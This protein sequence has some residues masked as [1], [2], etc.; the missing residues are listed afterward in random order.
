MQS[1]DIGRPSVPS[2]FFSTRNVSL[3]FGGFA[4][5]V[6]AFALWSRIPNQRD[7]MPHGYCYL[8][9]APLI[10]LHVASDAL[11]FLSY[12]SI[13][14]T[15]LYFIRRRRDV[16]FNWMFLCFGTFI[17]AC[18]FTHAMEVWTLWH[19]SYW[20]SGAVKA[21]TAFASVPTAVLLVRLVPQALAL[22]SPDALRAES[23]NRKR[24]ETKFRGLMESAPDAIV[25]VNGDGIITL[26]NAQTEKVFGYPREELLGQTVDLLVPERFRHRHTGHRTSFF[27]EPKV[28]PM[29]AS[30][31]LYGLRKDGNEFPVEI[32]LSPLETEE[33]ILVSAAIRDITERKIAETAL[34][35]SEER[36]SSAF[37]NAPI[38]MAL[39]ALDG[40]WLKVNRALCNLVGYS[41]EELLAG[42]FQDITHPD[43]LEADLEHV[44]R[45]V[46][47]EIPS[48]QMEKRYFHKSGQTIWIL[49][50]V[51]LVRDERGRVLNFISQIQD[52]TER[53]R[54]EAKFRGLLEAAPDAVVVVNRDGRIVLVNAQVEELFGYRR[55]ELLDNEIEMLI[56]ERFRGKHPGHRASFFRETRVRP[57]GAGLEL[58]GLHKGGHEFPV[59]ISLSPLE[60][61][62][63]VLVS[64]AIRDISAHRRI[65]EQLKT[66]ANRLQEQASLLDV[67]HDAIIVRHLDG[68][69]SFWNRGAETTYGFG[70]DEVLGRISHEVLKTEFSTPLEE[71]Q[72]SLLRNGRWEGELKHV[73]RNGSRVTVSSRWV[74]HGD[75]SSVLEINNDI[76]ARKRAELQFQALLEAAPDAMVVVNRDG[77]IVLVNAQTEKVFGYGREEMLGNEL[78][79]LIPER[80][81]GK[82]PGHRTNFFKETKVRPMGAGFELYGLHKDGHEF[83][84][85]ISL[86]PLETE[87][88]VLVSSAIRDITDRKKAEEA[89]RRSEERFRVLVE[90]VKD[91]AI[92]SLTP[93]GHVATWNLGAERIK[94]Y[95]ADEIIGQHFSCFYPEY[96]VRSGKPQRELEIAIKEGRVEDEGW[97]LRKDGT[98]FWANV[99]I[100]AL[101][102]DEGRLRGFSKIT[103]DITDRKQAEE[104][105]CLSEERTRLVVETALDAFIAMDSDGQVVNWNRQAEIT[106]GWSREEALGGKLADLI[107]P[108]QQREAHSRGLQHFMVAGE[109]PLLNKR[110]E[111][112]ALHKDGS[113]FPVE[114]TIAPLRLLNGYMFNAFVHDITSRKRA[115][116]AIRQQSTEV[117]RANTELEET[118]KELEAFTYSV[119]HDLRAPL[120][121]IQGFSKALMEDFG[122]SMVPAAQEYVTDIVQ[123]AQNMGQ[124]VDDLLGLARIGRQEL[125]VQVTALRSL[126]DEVWKDMKKETQDREIQWQIGDLPYA[127][128]DPGLMKQVFFNLLSNAVKYTGPRKPAVI[129]VGQTTVDGRPVVFVRDNGVGFNMKYADKLF[130]VFQRLHRKEDF[131]GTGVGLATVQRIVHKH[132]GRIWAEAEIDKGA[133]F[134]F[135]LGTTEKSAS[136]DRRVALTGGRPDGRGDRNTIG[137]GRS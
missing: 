25:V 121:H 102:D 2:R 117:A 72:A 61:E 56:P 24:V 17:I 31:E 98:R 93:D 65:E 127:D 3:T 122:S 10:W 53:R 60:T 130:G 38:G 58:Y 76:T 8:W 79:M 84:V 47:G 57:M 108:M 1:P 124:L 46:D 78:E 30:L 42:R 111:V 115:E 19:A 48:Y 135:T 74:L 136:E 69:I 129:Q 103:R 137:R 67:A 22:P 70:K 126:V 52:I 82:H 36:F 100:T 97:R 45:M 131:E 50:S 85:E 37:E 95:R 80:F 14:F 113:E 71:I 11:I 92:F 51:S 128:C 123:G 62:E 6:A 101:M 43:D 75:K 28:R 81:R 106:F 68:V 9:N 104:L 18:G 125:R 88:G 49:L 99:V 5:T 90:S 105:V 26:V 118:N 32:S 134:S 15:L 39:V 63:G 91:Y 66:Q 132:G 96:D 116:N 73:K 94:G 109:G 89:V 83:P 16:P 41:S 86:S 107:I 110:I 120:R 4:L 40:R 34:R 29:G 59:E 13:P 112:T 12:L 87:E 44:R 20:V 114:L 55:E 27:S 133:T 35:L 119:A 21:I 64:A 54:A 23:A 33:G 77:R 7:F